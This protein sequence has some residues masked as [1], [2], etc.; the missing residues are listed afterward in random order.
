MTKEHNEINNDSVRYKLIKCA[1]KTLKAGE[2]YDN[3]EDISF[4]FGYLYVVDGRGYEALFKIVTDKKTFYYAA[5]KNKIMRLSFNEE[6]FNDTVKKVLDLHANP[7]VEE[8][9]NVQDDERKKINNEYIHSLNISVNNG[10]NIPFADDS[11]ELKSLD[12]ICKKVISSILIVQVAC[13]IR[14]DNYQ[15][16]LKFF[17][18]IF[19][20]F[21]VLD[22]FNEKEQRVFDG[23]YTKE[24][25]AD[26][27]W[28][29]ETVW[30]VLYALDLVDDIK[31]ASMLCDYQ[32]MI[33]LLKGIT[34]DEFKAKCSLRDKKDILDMYDLYYRYNWACKE[35]KTN[36]NVSI[37][38]LIP[39]NVRERTRGLEWLLSSE[40]DWYK[41]DI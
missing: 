14:R 37:G 6:A 11:C 24:D 35:N 25:L 17:M 39:D 31:D 5:Q 18:P 20:K 22:S 26:L 41:L 13:D 29:Y 21:G 7:V 12:E 1:L 15:G 36:S 2:D 23:T 40:K 9:E 28:E 38:K 32:Y 30:A 4:G 33:D 34:F 10:L 27:D 3:I 19:E 16:S 8:K